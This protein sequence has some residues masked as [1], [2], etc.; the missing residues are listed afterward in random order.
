MT[1]ATQ[2][3]SPEQ[4]AAEAQA[5]LD[6]AANIV[7]QA[8]A[9]L[10]QMI[11]THHTEALLMLLRVTASGL[12]QSAPGNAR[13]LWDVVFD[14]AK[15]SNKPKEVERINRRFDAAYS[16]FAVEYNE[17]ARLRA[18]LMNNPPAGSA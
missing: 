8:A 10:A 16:A 12:Q 7:R 18:S 1:E 15:G 11:K 9:T 17:G 2:G 6:L 4:T 13:E 5:Q 14:V 3:P